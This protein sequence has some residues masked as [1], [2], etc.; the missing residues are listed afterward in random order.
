MDE[1]MKKLAKM[2]GKDKAKI[3]LESMGKAGLSSDE[4]TGII[5]EL[6]QQQSIGTDN[7]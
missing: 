1:N 3:H 2:Y 4:I 6:Q 5:K 7:G